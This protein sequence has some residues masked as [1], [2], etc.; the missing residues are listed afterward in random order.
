MTICP[1]F[2]SHYYEKA[3]GPFRNL[4]DLP[5]EQA[6]AIL[7]NI[8]DKGEVFAS[9]RASEYLTVRRNLEQTVRQLFILKGGKPLRERPHYMILGRCAWL[10]SWYQNGA[11]L[12]I[13]LSNFSAE[14]VSFTYGDT[15]PAMRLADGKPYRKI[16]YTLAEIPELV[17]TYG[18]PQT[19]NHNG[20]QG[21]DRY[22]EAQI[23]ANKPLRQFL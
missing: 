12:R 10:T 15:F 5:N 18:L 16:V 11:E 21:S 9:Q 13:P 7:K 4:S 3:T 22:I 8:R 1:N 17:S 6:E 14:I 2:L 20:K 23:W 19:W